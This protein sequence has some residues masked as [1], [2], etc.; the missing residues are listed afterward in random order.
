MPKDADAV[1]TVDDAPLT[2]TESWWDEEADEVEGYDLL[3][4]EALRSLVG[5]P[6]RI[7]NVTFREGTQRQGAPYRDD[8]VS[9]ELTVAPGEVFRSTA[10]RILSRRATYKLGPLGMAQPE[11]QLVINDGSTGVYRQ[12]MEYLRDSK[13]IVLPDGDDEGGKGESVLDL[14]RSQWV[15]GADAATEGFDLRLKCSRGLRFS[16]Y[17]NEYTKEGLT[18]YIA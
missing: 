10:D 12:I 18:W 13:L 4:D 9:C 5:V 2:T 17:E 11:E 15:S 14:P 8:Y 3:K 1:A 16:E 7:T 6:F